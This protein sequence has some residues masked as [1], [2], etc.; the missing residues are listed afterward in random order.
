MRLFAGLGVSSKLTQQ[1]Q[2]LPRTGLEDQRWVHPDDLHITLRFIGEAEETKLSEIQDVLEGVRVKHFSIV[3]RGLDAFVKKNQAA[4]YSPIESHRK[5]TH[6][7]AEITERM[8]RLGFEFPERA[9]APH[10]TLA[11]LKTSPGL[12][13]YIV[14]NKSAIHAEWTADK[15]YLFKSADP[16]N[17]G[18]ARYSVLR[19]YALE[20]Y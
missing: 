11:R 8:N 3:A 5:I 19:E 14:R 1:F 2:N 4:L 16:S 13:K 15:F 12:D 10:I 20:R 6:L 17:E 9:F 18:D 7:S